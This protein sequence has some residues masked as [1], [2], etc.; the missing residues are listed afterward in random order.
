MA[1]VAAMTLGVFDNKQ[2]SDDR[3]YA[4]LTLSEGTLPTL[5]PFL[6]GGINSSM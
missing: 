3:E 6:R 5:Q 1:A 4:L 2:V